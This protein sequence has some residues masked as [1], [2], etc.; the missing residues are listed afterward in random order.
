MSATQAAR[1]PFHVQV[2]D[3]TEAGDELLAVREAVFVAEQQVPLEEERDAYDPQCLHVLARDRDGKAVGTG[4]LVPPPADGAPARVGRMAVLRG[5]RG[6]GVGDAMLHAL[7]RAARG[8]GWTDVALNAQVSAQSFYARHGFAPVGGRFMEAGIQHQAMRRRIDRPQAVDDRDA[9]VAVAA[10]IIRQARRGLHVYTRE[11]DPGLLD[12]PRVL[13]AIRELCTRGDGAQVQVL[14]QDAAAPQRALAP[15]LALAQRLPSTIAFREVADPVDRT[16][17][18]AYLANDSGG[19]YFRPL[20]H[21]LEGEAETDA[22]GRARHLVEHFR[23]V[24]ERA[25]P[26]SEY[27]ALGL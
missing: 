13:D 2:V 25:R 4:R 9:A 6:A 14:L 1:G 7:L 15:L 19:Y 18:S 23:P 27:R 8:R 12:A 26:C 11:L 22:G 20:G 17:P 16:Y 10:A 21:R 3:F 5:W 24:W